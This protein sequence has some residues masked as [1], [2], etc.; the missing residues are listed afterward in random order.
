[1]ESQVRGRGA[2][3]VRIPAIAAGSLGLL[4]GVAWLS[5]RPSGA[6]Q[7]RTRRGD[8]VKLDDAGD[9]E[10][11]WKMGDPNWWN[12]RCPGELKIEGLGKKKFVN[13]YYNRPHEQTGGSY[14]DTETFRQIEVSLAGRGYLAENC[15]N[16]DYEGADPGSYEGIAYS[17]LYLLGKKLSYTMDFNGVGCGWAAS[18]TLNAMPDNTDPGGCNDFFCDTM[19]TCGVHCSE[20]GLQEANMMAWFSTLYADSNGAGSGVGYGGDN[21]ET[22]RRDWDSSKYG[23]NATCI[24]TTAPFQ[25]ALS[26][27]TD[28]EGNLQSMDVELSQNG[29]KVS[30]SADSHPSGSMSEVSEAMKK[31]MTLVFALW[32]SPGMGWLDGK[33]EDQAGPCAPEN[34]NPATDVLADQDSVKW[35]NFTLEDISTSASEVASETTGSSSGHHQ[36]SAGAK[37]KESTRL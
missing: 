19:K 31:G 18:L 10:R 6:A 2:L 16:P 22:P 37:A 35:A 8:A 21:G 13:A 5:Q 27:P 7:Q 15:T 14:A 1:V 32:G 17:R 3:R 26:F 28:A 4:A 9:G 20:V 25:V 23:P 12:N 11:P 33:G 29:C 24:K 36:A 30:A 34:E